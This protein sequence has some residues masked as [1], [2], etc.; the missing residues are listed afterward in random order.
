MVAAIFASRSLRAG[1]SFAD[2]CRAVDQCRAIDRH[3]FRVVLFS[4]QG[5]KFVCKKQLPADWI[6]RGFPR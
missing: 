4:S 2:Q 5:A 6:F 3:S 1:S